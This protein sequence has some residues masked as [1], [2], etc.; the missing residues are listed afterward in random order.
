MIGKLM[1]HDYYAIHKDRVFPVDEWRKPDGF[2][3]GQI[4]GFHGKS[5]PV[6]VKVV[7]S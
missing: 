2:G 5:I 6:G 4:E 1:R 3:V 7:Y